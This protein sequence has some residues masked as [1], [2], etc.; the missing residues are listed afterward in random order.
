VSRFSVQK[1]KVIF[2]STQHNVFIVVRRRRRRL[3][4]R[5]ASQYHIANCTAVA[6]THSYSW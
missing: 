2:S 1:V 4:R 6:Y 5:R 3:G